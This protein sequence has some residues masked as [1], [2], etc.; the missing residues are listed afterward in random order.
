M[1]TVKRVKGR[2]ALAASAAAVLLVTVCGPVTAMASPHRVASASMLPPAKPGTITEQ[3]YYTAGD[4][5]EMVQFISQFEK[6]NPGF[7][8]NR[9]I[10]PSASAEVPD[11]DRGCF[12]PAPR[13]IDDGQPRRAGAGRGRR[14]G[15]AG[16]PRGE[17]LGP[18]RR[19]DSG[20]EL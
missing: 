4:N 8:V 15:P 11:A 6:A 7:T 14:P 1:L 12:A 20:G 9:D 10:F 5:T 3:D 17:H 16:Q 13:P 18:D 2:S 19:G